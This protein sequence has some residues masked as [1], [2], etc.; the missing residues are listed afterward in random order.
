MH[1]NEKGSMNLLLKQEA[2][3]TISKKNALLR[4]KKKPSKQSLALER[5]PSPVRS[6]V[7]QT[8]EAW[9]LDDAA[10]RYRESSAD[11]ES[12]F[13]DDEK[14]PRPEDTRRPLSGVSQP[15]PSETPAAGKVPAKTN[16][17]PKDGMY[18]FYQGAD[19]Q[20]LY[21]HPLD[22]KVLKYEY[23]EYDNFPDR[24]TATAIRVQESTVNEVCDLQ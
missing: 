3:D 15:A 8:T 24:I 11:V 7:S 9:S 14:T 2:M 4:N 23:G 6:V 5:A 17:P 18:Y 21:L 19:G 12:A 22:I 13:S 16:V 20:H 10:Q 1:A